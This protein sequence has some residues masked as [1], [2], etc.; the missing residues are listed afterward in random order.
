MKKKSGG[1]REAQSYRLNP[2]ALKLG[3]AL[4]EAPW[5]LGVAQPNRNPG[6][7]PRHDSSVAGCLLGALRHFEDSL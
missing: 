1:G 6:Q 5:P 4:Q 7:F 2:N 3:H